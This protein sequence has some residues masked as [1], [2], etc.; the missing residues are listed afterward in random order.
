MELYCFR[1]RDQVYIAPSVSEFNAR[2]QTFIKHIDPMWITPKNSELQNWERINVAHIKV[3]L[4]LQ[5]DWQYTGLWQ[6]PLYMTDVNLITDGKKLDN[7]TQNSPP[8]PKRNVTSP[9]INRWQEVYFYWQHD[10]I[11]TDRTGQIS[12]RF[13]AVIEC[14]MFKLCPPLSYWG[15]YLNFST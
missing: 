6:W 15:G 1:G 7:K 2:I 4:A 10:T 9:Q 3:K 5:T 8:P 11:R 14:K 12:E 13:V